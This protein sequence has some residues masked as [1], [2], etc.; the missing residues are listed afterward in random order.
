MASISIGSVSGDGHTI[1][2]GNTVNNSFGTPSASGSVLTRA[3]Y[4]Q[5]LHEIWDLGRV[6]VCDYLDDRYEKHIA[7]NPHFAEL[8]YGDVHKVMDGVLREEDGDLAVEDGDFAV[9]NGGLK[10]TGHTNNF[11]DALT[12][13]HM[14]VV[15]KIM[16]TPD[17]RIDRPFEA[18]EK[19]MDAFE[20]QFLDSTGD[21]LNVQRKLKEMNEALKA[22]RASLDAPKGEQYKEAAKQHQAD[23]PKVF[24]S[25]TW[26]DDIKTWVKELATRLRADGI[27]VTLD[28]WQLAPGDQLTHFM[29]TAVR[30]NDY[31]LIICTPKYKD[32]S[33][34]RAGGV[35]YEGDIMTAE[36]CCSG[37]HRKYIPV[38]QA[39]SFKASL[40]SWLAGKVCLDLSGTQ[41]NETGYRELVTTLYEDR[42][43]APRLGQ[44]PDFISR[45]SDVGTGK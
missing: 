2:N 25:Y 28:Q 44:R 29:E 5:M 34:N 19:K 22:E 17:V 3:D 16:D 12:W 31:V 7:K 4:M 6:S 41:L 21:S 32:R 33:D 10:L 24:I 15:E 26:E 18:F 43:A 38:L 1:G 37:S 35:G 11:Y 39:G 40:P 20:A 23:N 36:V 14:K 9:E 27:D 13:L 45:V 42:E 8:L 30:Q